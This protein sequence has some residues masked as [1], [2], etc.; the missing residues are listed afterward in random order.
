[1]RSPFTMNVRELCR[2]LSATLH[3]PCVDGWAEELHLC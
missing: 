1:M 3:L 2:V